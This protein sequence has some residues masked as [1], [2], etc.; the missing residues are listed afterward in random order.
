VN[1]PS[2][3]Y[4]NRSRLGSADRAVP[5]RPGRPPTSHSHT[6]SGQRVSNEQIEEWLLELVSGEEHGYGY[7]MFTECLRRQHGLIIN[8][9]KVYRLCRK[10]GLLHPQRRKKTHYPRRLARNHEITNL[11]QLWQ[12]DIKY[13]YVAGY[14]QFFFIADM[15]DVFDRGIVG[16]YRGSSCDAASVCAM[17]RTALAERLKPEQPR[18]IIR[19]DNGPQFVSKA[20]GELAE[21]LQ[22]VHERIPP[23]TPNMNAYIESFHAQVEHWLLRKESFSTFEE[24]FEAVDAF[25]DFYNNRRMHKSL[26]KRSPAEFRE[27]IAAAKPDLTPFQVAL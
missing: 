10:L 21:E 23:K 20:F 27:W 16:Y 9:K 17:V 5:V 1:V 26:G 3:T 14:D 24:A 25:M 22:F 13:G 19:T 2:S 4:Y 12:L 15:I 11:N 8:K 7:E 18:P 6:V